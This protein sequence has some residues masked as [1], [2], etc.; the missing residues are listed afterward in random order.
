MFKYLLVIAVMAGLFFSGKVP[1]SLIHD[2]DGA[3]KLGIENPLSD[4]DIACEVDKPTGYEIGDLLSGD[5]SIR[6]KNNTNR[7]MLAYV[8][9]EIIPPKGFGGIQYKKVLLNPHEEL[10]LAFRSSTRYV[11]AGTYK[12][13]V[14]YNVGWSPDD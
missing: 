4:R 9:G 13:E 7:F 14:R 5:F 1:Y 11:G 10:H 8:E 2:I 3:S 6:L 12:C